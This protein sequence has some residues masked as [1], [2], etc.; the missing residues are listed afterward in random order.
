M[1]QNGEEAASQV[2]EVAPYIAAPFGFC[3]KQD[4]AEFHGRRAL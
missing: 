4:A 1:L 2:K 3:L